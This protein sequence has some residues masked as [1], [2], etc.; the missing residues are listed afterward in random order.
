M[1]A[2]YWLANLKTVK[3]GNGLLEVGKSAFEN[4]ANMYGVGFD[5]GSVLSYISDRAFAG[6]INLQSFT[7]PVGVT[8]IYDQA[9]EA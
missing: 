2:F 4:C 7:L 5:F 1:T 6:C 3:F 9:F 8:E